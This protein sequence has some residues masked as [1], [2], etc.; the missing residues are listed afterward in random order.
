MIFRF[1][2]ASAAILAL[3]VCLASSSF[4]LDNDPAIYRLCRTCTVENDQL[5]VSEEAQA[6]YRDLVREYGVAFGPQLSSPAKTL[7]INGFQF[8]VQFAI[9]SINNQGQYWQE[10]VED[11]RPESQLMV[12]RIGL[13]KGLAASLEFGSDVAYLVNSEMWSLGGFIKWSPHEMMDDFPVD[14]AIRGSLSKTV[15]S[16]QLQVTMTGADVVLGK[17]FG[18][19]G[20]V[21][22]SALCRLLPPWV[23]GSS[24]I[25]DANPGIPNDVEGQ[26]RG[27]FVFATETILVQRI[28]FGMRLV[29]G[30]FT[31]TPEFVLAEKQQ[32]VNVNLGLNF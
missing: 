26:S 6:N 25:L 18:L 32:T 2:Q 19:G 24:G 16:P 28:A 8:D 15:G 13:R 1:Q 12:T 5:K 31:L 29:T 17:T 9:T 3:S 20:V 27:E 23:S 11:E 7:G 22:L 14:L 21:N 10:G 30:L 4:A